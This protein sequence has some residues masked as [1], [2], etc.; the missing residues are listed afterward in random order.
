MFKKSI[1][2][3]MLAASL[4]VSSSS[5]AFAAE[6]ES[7]VGKGWWDAGRVNTTGVPI[8]DGDTVTF[9]IT[10]D[11]PETADDTYGAVCVEVSDGTLYWTTTSDG[12]CWGYLDGTTEIGTVIKDMN[13][14]SMVRGGS[15]EVVV[16]REGSNF[17]ATYTDLSTGE[18]MF[19]T[20]YFTAGDGFTFG[21]TTAYI[22][23]QA[24]NGTV[25]VKE[26]AVEETATEDTAAATDDAAATT[27]VPKTG[28]VGFGVVYGLA[29][30]ATGAV[31]LKRKQK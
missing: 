28:V 11:A 8:A 7:F 17:T 25:T 10:L 26:A 12:D 18:A 22:I 15:Y 9:D 29:A 16:T 30:L 14:A 5:V 23:P 20:L 6:S 3:V 2:A 27:D 31:A 21:D 1:M 13:K 24:G 4:I 19:G